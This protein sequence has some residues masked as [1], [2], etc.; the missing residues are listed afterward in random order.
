MTGPFIQHPLVASQQTLG[1]ESPVL[2]FGRAP[3]PELFAVPPAGNLSP[4]FRSAV[5]TAII[6]WLWPVI[7]SLGRTAAWFTSF[8][9]ALSA[10]SA[11]LVQAPHS[12]VGEHTVATAGHLDVHLCS[13]ISICVRKPADNKPSG[14]SSALR[15]QLGL[16]HLLSY[17]ALLNSGPGWTIIP[18]EL[19][20][21]AREF[22]LY[23]TEW[24]LHRSSQGVWQAACQ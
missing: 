20:K 4:A 8:P 2:I 6:L 15:L 21:R 22:C 1:T 13:Q 23:I 12:S 3:A 17:L 16:Q 5:E 7:S 11:L 10:H 19:A 14:P 18:G 24:C 9:I